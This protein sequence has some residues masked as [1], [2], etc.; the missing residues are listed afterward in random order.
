ML[1]LQF[2]GLALLSVGSSSTVPFLGYDRRVARDVFNKR[3]GNG[4][5]QPC[6]NE[7]APIVTAPKTNPWAA[8][9]PDENVAVWDLLHDPTSGLNLTDPNEAKLTD[10]YVYVLSPNHWSLLTRV[11]F[12]VDALHT[13]KSEVLPYLDS[14]AAMPAKF[15]RAIIFEGGKAEPD[16]Q[17]YM[18]G[19]LPVSAK[20]TIERLDYIYND[21]FGGSV[22]YNARYFDGP[23]EAATEPLIASIMSNISDI[24]AA[25][26][27]GGAYY[28][29]DDERSSL[30]FFSDTPISFDGTSAFRNIMFR[31]PG[32]ATF[33]TPLDF[34]LLIDCTGTDPSLYFL[35]GF[36]TN[37]KFYTSVADLRAAFEV[38]QI[39]MNYDQTMEADWAL[40]NYKPEMGVRE[41]EE[42]LAPSTLEIGGKRYKLD[43]ENQYVEYMGWS[44]YMSFSRTLGIML[45]DIKFKGERILYELSMQEATAQYG[46]LAY[47]SLLYLAD[48][49]KVAINQKLRIL[50]TTTLIFSSALL[51][52]AC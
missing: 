43:K 10:N 18:I 13:N 32:T 20:T 40:V 41:L 16:S 3:V 44:F 26:F 15:A 2:A 39:A 23:R 17:E 24:T 14:D 19:P 48:S 50:S 9:T 28:G 21:G 4:T 34:Y 12:W 33:L 22:P 1:P 30:T 36:V 37:E 38:G 45:Y 8:L 27:Q 35:K 6:L 42:R 49:T 7:A 29:S 46:E 11:R 31:F 51:W 52:V 5:A 47:D 25:L